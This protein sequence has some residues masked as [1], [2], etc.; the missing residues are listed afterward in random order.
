MCFGYLYACLLLVVTFMF[1]AKW[2]VLSTPMFG[3]LTRLHARSLVETHQKHNYFEVVK[4]I[5]PTE[6]H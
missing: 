6:L 5:G 1:A 4:V 2:G 3:T